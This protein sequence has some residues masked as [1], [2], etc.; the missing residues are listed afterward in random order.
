MSPEDNKGDIDGYS[1]IQAVEVQRKFQ[2]SD[3]KA[4]EVSEIVTNSARGMFLL[5]KLIWLNLLGQTSVSGLEEELEER[6]FPREVN[7]AYRRI[8]HRIKTQASHAELRDALML[9]GWLVCAKRPLRW[10]E[11]QGLKSINLD[12]LSVE[13]ERQRFVVAPKDLCESLVEVRV[14]GTLELVHQTVKFASEEAASDNESNSFLIEDKHV[15]QPVEELKMACLCIDYL[16]L[17]AFI[18]PPTQDG[19][20]KGDYVFMDYAV[21]N[22]LRHLEAG[23]V[24]AD[25]HQQLMNQLAESLEVFIHQ[26]WSSPSAHFSVSNGNRDRLQFFKDLPF[27]DKLEKTIISTRKQLSFFGQMRQGEIAL[28]LANIVVKVRAVMESILSS[29]I[30]VESPVKEGLQEK[31]GSNLF[32]CYRFSCQFF[33]AGF[34]AAHERDKHIER[35]DRRFRCT[36]EAC[37]GFV[38]GFISEKER[39]KHMKTT[40]A[41]ADIQDGKFPTDEDVRNSVAEAHE[42]ERESLESESSESSEFSESSEPQ[43]ALVPRQS[44]KPKRPRQT[45]FKCPHC[46]ATYNRR[47]NLQSHLYTHTNERPYLFE[48]Q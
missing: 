39:D 2:L 37:T 14:D 48:A 44:P 12:K 7:D 41:A 1:Q 27:Y 20:L 40:H 17:P 24:H 38:L 6:I 18:E 15:D 42:V 16:N 29:T 21:L 45:S 5:A 47:Y 30:G 43:G 32:K 9:L 34:S 8:M 23:V 11:V 25:A 19:V 4:S 3:E 22:W 33:T 28:N 31:Y 13:Y 36:D 26:H 46:P 10:H 35:H